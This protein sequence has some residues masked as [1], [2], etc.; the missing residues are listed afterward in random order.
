MSLQKRSWSDLDSRSRAAVIVLSAFEVIVTLVAARDLR[1]R[2]SAQ[3]KGPKLF[4]V[5]AFA[6]Q[7][8]GPLAYLAV[9]RRRDNG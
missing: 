7:P 9:G 8:V 3:V 2:P 6:V 4:W 5:L 1:K